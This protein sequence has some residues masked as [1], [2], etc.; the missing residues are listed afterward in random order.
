VAVAVAVAGACRRC[1]PGCC[2]TH[3]N[4]RSTCPS[5]NIFHTLAGLR[6]TPLKNALD[7]VT[8]GT[9]VVAGAG[10]DTEQEDVSD[11]SA[12]VGFVVDNMSL[13]VEE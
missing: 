4:A 8:T 1:T 2:W 12:A 6:N 3:C 10:D 13:A 7:P 5:R 11:P 9:Q